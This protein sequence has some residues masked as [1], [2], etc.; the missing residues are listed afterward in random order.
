MSSRPKKE[1]TFEEAMDRLEAIVSEIES[2][3]LGLERQF[4]LFQEGMALARFCDTKLTDVQKSV[5]VVLKDA[6]GE[7]KTEAFAEGNAPPAGGDDDG[8]DRD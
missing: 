1:R 4:E 7:W 5:D 8:D 3:G 6:S 2:D